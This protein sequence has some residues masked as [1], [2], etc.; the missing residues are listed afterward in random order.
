[1]KDYQKLLYKILLYGTC[2]I[3]LLLILEAM[4]YY[5]D[6]TPSP[7]QFVICGIL[8]VTCYFNLKD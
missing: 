3:L 8:I 6:S 2:I 5:G 4:G 7:L 1:M